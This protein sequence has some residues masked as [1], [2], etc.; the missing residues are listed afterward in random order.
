MLCVRAMAGVYA[1]MFRSTELFAPI[2]L[3][4][5]R[6]Y[7]LSNACFVSHLFLVAFQLSRCLLCTVYSASLATGISIVYARRRLEK[8][9]EIVEHEEQNTI[10]H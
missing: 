4:I 2:R 3:V 8:L 7:I 1:N 9:N 10:I 5:D 6:K